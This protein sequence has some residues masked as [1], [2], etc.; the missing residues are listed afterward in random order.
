M[1]ADR[2]SRRPGTRPLDFD[3]WIAEF[4][5]RFQEDSGSASERRGYR[6]DL[7]VLKSAV[8]AHA[9]PRSGSPD[10]VARV[11]VERIAGAPRYSGS[12]ETRLRRI[13]T[14][15]DWLA[16]RPGA[17]AAGSA[18]SLREA[19][20]AELRT[21]PKAPARPGHGAAAKPPGA[22]AA[23]R[24]S[25]FITADGGNLYP[26]P[27]SVGRGSSPR[28]GGTVF[29]IGSAEDLAPPDAT[30]TNGD[31]EGEPSGMALAE[32]DGGGFDVA[33]R[34]QAPPSRPGF[35]SARPPA[36]IPPDPPR[37][38]PPS[39][40]AADEAPAP[41]PGDRT[42]RPHRAY[43]RLDAPDS[44]TVGKA[45]KLVIGLT[46]TPSARTA[47]GEL[48]LPPL[49]D[50]PYTLEI[51][52]VADT[53]DIG[54]GESF[55]IGLPVSRKKPY[56][57]AV[58]HLIARPQLEP[59]TKRAIQ[60]TFGIDGE[61]VGV[62]IRTIYVYATAVARPRSSRTSAITGISAAVPIGE[63]PADVTLE[64]FIAN[65]AGQMRWS[66]RSPHAGVASKRDSAIRQAIPGAPRDFARDVKRS[67]EG[68]DPDAIGQTLVGI[69]RNVGRAVPLGIWEVIARA[70]KT[71]SD[72]P[73]DILILSEEPYV[74]WELAIRPTSVRGGGTDFLGAVAN[75]GRWLLGHPPPPTPDPPRSVRAQSIG[76][77]KGQ[78]SGPTFQRLPGAAR[79]VAAL[80]LRYGAQPVKPAAGAMTDLLDGVPTFDVIHFAVHG[81]ADDGTTDD[82]LVVAE[83]E[84]ARTVVLGP[85]QVDG[86]SL[87]SGSPFVFLNACQVGAA[88]VSLA[89]YAGLA[90]SFLRWGASAVVAPIWA[91]DD[92]LS[93]EIA[94]DLYARALVEP[95]PP[96]V[97]SILR[98]TRAKFDRKTRPSA[99]YLAYQLYG[100]PT[101]RLVRAAS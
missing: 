32:S 70:R 35:T 8:S 59:K 25:G 27:R 91:I 13:F 64:I 53:F 52:L 43:G 11:V 76:V 37:D 5:K 97:A 30:A 12:A 34:P 19:I 54:P 68:S 83:T 29:H 92:E 49:A 89:T 31:A 95:D 26:T 90:A 67:V 87:T 98:E 40:A 39:T 57:T 16:S 42:T 94:L 72:R 61:T 45:F 15:L 23:D 48:A 82:G 28:C 56:P 55:R 81:R 73:L 65:E 74:P 2:P 14:F 22:V 9:G 21:L 1:S 100:H 78:Y 93:H 7:S 4:L 96:A 85:N 66:A 17:Q 77:I 84:A 44:A 63:K 33:A 86:G 24:G 80:R 6:Q 20:R 50:E 47:A 38:R 101:M 36:P 71:V 60:A 10:K 58:L 75:V 46:R 51:Q 62:A 88:R 3:E 18:G 41:V 79:E 99:T 69:G